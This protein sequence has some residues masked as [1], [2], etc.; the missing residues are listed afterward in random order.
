MNGTLIKYFQCLCY[1]YHMYTIDNKNIKIMKIKLYSKYIYAISS[2]N[3]DK[4]DNDMLDVC[5]NSVE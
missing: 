1:D 5:V 3:K 4:L 2:I